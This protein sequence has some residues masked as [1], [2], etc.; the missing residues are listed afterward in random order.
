ML[1]IIALTLFPE[2]FDAVTAYGITGKALKSGL[3]SFSAL[4]LRDFSVNRRGDVD[5]RP[6]GGGPG[7]VIRPE[8]VY[9]AVLE[10]K[11]RIPAPAWVVYLTPQGKKLNNEGVLSLLSKENLVFLCG[12]YE[13]V[14][15]R[16]IG[17]VVDEEISIGDYVLSGG[18]LPAM[19]LIDTLVRWL[20]TALGHPESTAQDSFAS[21]LLDCPHYTRPEVFMGLSVPDVLLSGNHKAI[22]LWRKK[23]AFDRTLLRRPD[24][25][26]ASCSL[27]SDPPHCWIG[28][29]QA[30]KKV[31]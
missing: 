4:N 27:V 7:M 13:G 1:N 12:R 8:P 2:M 31:D 24:L 15:E 20:P 5:D 14:D 9:A 28:K 19:V 18:E 22:E 29:E 3:F 10:A 16:A 6:F 21:G 11:S 23:E 25:V 30:K 17:L 26:S